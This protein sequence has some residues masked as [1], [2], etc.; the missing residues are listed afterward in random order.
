MSIKVFEDQNNLVPTSSFPHVKYP[1]EF[2][3]PVQ[4][5]IMEFYDTDANCLVAS[6]TGSGK[7]ISSEMFAAYEI[8]KNKKKVIYVAPMRTLAQEKYDEWNS[9]NWVFSNIKTSILTGD[10]RINSKRI[11][12]LEE[13]SIIV[14][15]PES[16]NSRARNSKS[17]T[18]SF[19]HDAGLIIY[20]EFHIVGTSRGSHG[21]S[22]I[23]KLNKINPNLKFVMLSGTLPNS[24]EISK[25]IS[26]ITGRNTNIIKSTY[27]PTKLN[28]HFP[29]YKVISGYED[30]EESKINRA[31]QIIDSYPEDKFLVFAHGK[32]TGEMM[33]ERLKKR[34]IYSDFHNG[35]LVLEKRLKIE[36]EFK[37]GSMRVLV[38]TSTLAWGCCAIGTEIE[39]SNGKRKVE[40]LKEG[41][42]VLS[43]NGK[44]LVTD[45][46]SR[47]G[48]ACADLI[49][50]YFDSDKEIIVSSDH[51][52]Y[53]ED[54]C[55]SCLD[56]NVGDKVLY[57]YMKFRTIEKIECVGKG[58]VCKVEVL[59]NNNMVSNGVISHNCNLPARRVIILGV[60]RGKQEVETYNILQEI[61]RA[62]RPKYDKEGDAYILLPDI[63]AL[64]QKERVLKPEI[65]RSQLTEINQLA[66]HLVSEIHHREIATVLDLESWYLKTFAYAQK[67]HVG[68]ADCHE[69]VTRLKNAGC[70]KINGNDL[71]TT[72]IGAAAS[73]FYF[74]PF[75]VSS[76]AKNITTLINSGKTDTLH[77]AF[78][79]SCI[80]SC[81]IENPTASETEEIEKW[82]NNSGVRKTHASFVS[83]PSFNGEVRMAFIYYKLMSGESYFKASSLNSIA[84]NVKSDFERTSEMLDCLDKLSG[85]W[86]ISDVWKELRCRVIYGVEAKYAPLVRLTGIGKV[87]ATKLYEAGLTSLDLIS[88][89][90]DIIIKA[91]KCK[92]EIADAISAEAHKLFMTSG[93]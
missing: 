20:D 3:N 33:L 43:F 25:W 42:E 19:I 68:I 39:T 12:E 1:F 8:F 49:K 75:D 18:S 15:T 80:P 54:G 51:A 27:R 13:S 22:A 70:I 91:L 41:D 9:P 85:K 40:Q 63:H 81:K 92:P 77:W 61:G 46:V 88:K 83:S 82:Y 21:E 58:T 76:M 14:T 26:N 69:A 57:D 93:E 24:E 53:G 67:G 56:L 2:F 60:H 16:L 87:K 73:M 86:K 35:D 17:E 79:L 28:L 34:N 29:S 11:S 59:R 78:A 30:N 52:F 45:I 47:V 48:Y 6:G 31:M 7:T 64:K 72:P 55:V 71:E 62:G 37:T 38:A 44:R 74:D 89:N 50:F 10:Y 66:F 65:I 5:R 36:N 84:R 23:I 90:K 4:S 32:R